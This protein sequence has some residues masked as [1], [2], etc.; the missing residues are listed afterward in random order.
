MRP[1]QL[2]QPADGSIGQIECALSRVPSPL[3]GRLVE[4][5]PPACMS[6]TGTITSSSSTFPAPAS[7]ISTA[8]TGA[9]QE[10][11][12]RSSGRCVADRPM[13][14]GACRPV[15]APRSGSVAGDEGIEALKREGEVRATLGAGH[16]VDLVDDDELDA[17]QRLARLAGEQQVEAT[18][19]W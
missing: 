6:S 11:G 13:R 15:A 16:G 1:D 19:A 3:V 18:P 5:G 7:V 10:A 14:C 9:A 17:A 2:Q 4:R 8:W 12:D